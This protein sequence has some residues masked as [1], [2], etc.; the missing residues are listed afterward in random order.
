L[1]RRSPERQQPKDGRRFFVDR[2]ARRREYGKHTKSSKMTQN[3]ADAVFKVSLNLS[4]K[5]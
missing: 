2:F 3:A 1:Y 4:L 5:E